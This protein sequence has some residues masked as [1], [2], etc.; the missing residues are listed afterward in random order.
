M[1]NITKFRSNLLFGL[2][3]EKGTTSHLSIISHELDKKTD[4]NKISTAATFNLWTEAVEKDI[5]TYQLAIIHFNGREVSILYDL[6]RR[7]TGK[8]KPFLAMKTN[9]HDGK[10][11]IVQLIPDFPEDKMIQ[12]MSRKVNMDDILEV[13]SGDDLVT[14][15]SKSEKDKASNVPSSQFL[16]HFKHRQTQRDC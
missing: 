10:G 11:S 8:T 5:N 12:K 15:S 9:N 13:K 6:T 14:K 1:T 2:G 7:D 3:A 4:R 16:S